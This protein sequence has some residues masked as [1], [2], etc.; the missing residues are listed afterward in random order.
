M[1]DAAGNRRWA[2]FRTRDQVIDAVLEHYV[3]WRERA[4]ATR[5]AYDRFTIAA[6]RIER[7]A[8]FA[9]FTETLNEEQL[10]A[11][12]YENSLAYAERVL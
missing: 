1:L 5:F 8:A 7:A 12:E 9:A 11:E 10:A 2:L 6:T 3:N 4:A